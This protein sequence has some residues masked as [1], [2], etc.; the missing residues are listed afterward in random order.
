MY[1][2]FSS[3]MHAMI[4]FENATENALLN[5]FIS[6]VGV[7]FKMCGYQNRNCTGEIENITMKLSREAQQSQ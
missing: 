5:H 2:F 7:A 4:I 3:A 6:R 1:V